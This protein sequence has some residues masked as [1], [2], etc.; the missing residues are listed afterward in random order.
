MK[1]R[2]RGRCIQVWPACCPRDTD[3]IH[4]APWDWIWAVNKSFKSAKARRGEMTVWEEDGESELWEFIMG[5]K[6]VHAKKERNSE[7]GEDFIVMSALH[8]WDLGTHPKVAQII[9][10]GF[11]HI[12]IQSATNINLLITKTMKTPSTM[13]ICSFWDTWAEDA[14]TAICASILLVFIKTAITSWFIPNTSNHG[15]KQPH[16]N[17]LENRKAPVSI[18]ARKT[19]QTAESRPRRKVGG[20]ENVG[21]LHRGC[22]T[23]Y[24]QK[25]L[26]AL[27]RVDGLRPSSPGRKIAEWKCQTSPRSQ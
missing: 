26:I 7:S 5:R 10:Q 14:P 25:G 3:V 2:D 4:I 15:L 16:T 23:I 13:M 1:G 8:L 24:S 27:G 6:E 19:F 20:N 22:N 9:F 18:S 17:Y 21:W 12:E 11:C